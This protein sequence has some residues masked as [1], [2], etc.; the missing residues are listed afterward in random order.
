MMSEV[1]AQ[2]NAFTLD[3]LLRISQWQMYIVWQY[4]M[5]PSMSNL[6]VSMMSIS[7]DP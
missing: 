6:A 1:W 7:K 3:E 4:L 2:S 5:R